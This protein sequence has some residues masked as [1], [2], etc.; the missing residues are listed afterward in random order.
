MWV[1]Q[2][3]TVD[4]SPCEAL[5]AAIAVGTIEYADG[6]DR[7]AQKRNSSSCQCLFR[8]TAF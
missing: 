2:Y 1:K 8:I 5:A 3:L 6:M 7:F 4:V